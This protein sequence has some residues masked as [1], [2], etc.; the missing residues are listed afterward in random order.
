[1]ATLKIGKAEQELFEKIVKFTEIYEGRLKDI[2][3]GYLGG[4]IE[5][6]QAIL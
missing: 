3:F 5:K 2:I 6:K 4:T 1:M